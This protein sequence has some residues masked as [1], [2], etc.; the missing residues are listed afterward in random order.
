MSVLQ[1]HDDADNLIV[2]TDI[3][4]LNHSNRCI[5]VGTD[6]DLLVL[7]SHKCKVNHEVYYYMPGTQTIP[8]ATYNIQNVQQSMSP[9]LK[10]YILFLHVVT[11]CDTTSAL[12]FQ[13]K[14]KVMSIINKN[15]S[16][17][18]VIDRFYATC[19]SLDIV[20][21]GE[22][23][24]LALYGAP[25]KIT[26]LDELRYTRF[27]KASKR[28]LQSQV[29][30][31]SLPPTSSAS[32]EH[33]LCVYF[34]L[35]LWLQTPRLNAVV[36]I[37]AHEWGW[38]R[39]DGVLYPIGSRKP[40]A[41]DEL[42]Q[43]ISCGCKTGCGKS[44]SCRKSAVKCSVLC[45]ICIGVSCTNCVEIITDVE[46]KECGSEEDDNVAMITSADDVDEE[47]APM[48]D[49]NNGSDTDDFEN[50]SHFQSPKRKLD[51]EEDSEHLCTTNVAKCKK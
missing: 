31:A 43:M 6:T 40:V 8:D 3:N 29:N 44:C 45:E 49:T 27:L 39:K 38:E 2:Q 12:F 7:L 51:N 20:N 50:A 47:D 30:M 41:P 1:D 25:K 18:P 5:V 48:E 24:L 46:E 33:S 26:S 9:H 35:Q 32:R 19:S 37:S 36:S 4:T 14:K 23:F 10:K 13:G 34:Q 11:G 21:A 42:L 16:L 22:K 15:P 28:S 17:Y